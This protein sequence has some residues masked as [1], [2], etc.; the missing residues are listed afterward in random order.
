MFKPIGNG[1]RFSLLLVLVLL[2]AC[3]G[4]SQ[5]A[6][7][8]APSSAA[9]TTIAASG[10]AASTSPTAAP[11]TASTSGAALDGAR[12]ATY[13]APVLGRSDFGVYKDDTYPFSVSL[14]RER[15]IAQARSSAYNIIV[16]DKE[17]PGPTNAIVSV[18]VLPA[19][20]H[21]DLDSTVAT[22]EKTLAAQPSIA[23]FAVELARNATVNGLLAQERIYTYTQG[24]IALR[25][26]I[27][28]VNGADHIYGV[29]LF[30]Q[31]DRYAA[32]ET[33]FEDVL[34]T[35]KGS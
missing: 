11:S 6:A 3:G 19:S 21:I 7:H 16:S 26:R 27:V 15:Y 28:Y 10:A 25:H 31:P 17:T 12:S 34:A 8:S 29:G 33:L 9:N 2:T 5:T 22:A 32:N 23:N 30:G 13:S 4:G 20:Q 35:F 18:L 1:Y 24:G 14:P